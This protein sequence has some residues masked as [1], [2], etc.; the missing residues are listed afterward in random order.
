MIVMKLLFGIKYLLVGADVW[1][2]CL[3]W[4]AAKYRGGW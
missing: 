3:G 1:S 4:P 2:W